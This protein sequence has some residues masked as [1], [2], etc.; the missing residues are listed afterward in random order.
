MCRSKRWA[1]YVVSLG[2]VLGACA[3]PPGDSAPDAFDVVLDPSV[4]SQ[5]TV[6]GAAWS[7][8][9]L[10][11]V[12]AYG[13]LKSVRHNPAADDYLIELRARA[14]LAA[15]WRDQQGKP[16][17]PSD[18][19]LDRL[20]EIDAAGNL[21]EHVL[22]SLFKPGWTIPAPEL[23]RIDWSALEHALPRGET[24]TYAT[25]RPRSGKLSSDIPGFALPDPIALHPSQV[26][27]T[28]SLPTLRRAIADWERE[29]V[30]LD[31]APAPANSDAEF[32]A[33][34]AAAHDDPPFRTRGATWVSPRVYLV[35]FL[36][37]FCAN[38]IEDY[39]DAERW[40]ESAMALVPT[41]PHAPNE[42]THALVFQRKFDRA[43]AV[44][45]HVLAITQD[46]CELARAW[47]RRG[48]IRF[49]Q[50]RLDESRIAYQRSLEYDPDSKIARSELELLRRAIVANGGQPDWYVP[51]ASR[52][53][54]TDCSD[55]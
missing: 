25:A 47:R 30:T 9:G 1:C 24:P 40:L 42:L 35:L 14:E 50:R 46:R 6:L 27:C 7:V 39:P 32:L 10:A 18:S 15:F 16:D 33:L 52:T 48:Y 41:S 4:V 28:Q 17:V 36:A 49:E 8:Y 19:Y 22:A 54:V 26:P 13:D 20:V 55:N 37:G 43:D 34:I 12:K 21:E 44:I 31:G 38:E 3:T 5:S 11:R 23:E 29:R 53:L 51:P 45:D 2:W